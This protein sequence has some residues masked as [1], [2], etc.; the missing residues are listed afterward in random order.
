MTYQESLFAYDFA[1]QRAVGKRVLDVGS[2][3][4]YGAA[5]VAERAKEII[6]LDPHRGIIERARRQYRSSNIQF[7]TGTLEAPPAALAEQRFDLVCC[8]QTIEHV[9]NQGAFLEQLKSFANAGGEVII[10]TPNKGRFPGFNPYHVKE[11]TLHDLTQ[12]MQ[13]HFQ[14]FSVKG[15][16]GDEDVLAYRNSKQRVS[17]TV[18]A[19]DVL[20]AREWLP[21]FLVRSLYVVGSGLVKSLSYRQQPLAVAAVSLKNFWVS[22][23]DLPNALDLLAV[24]EIG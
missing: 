5:Y 6:G 24:G 12:L 1:R 15:I 22:G 4:G 9:S 21:R 2:G 14:R 8:F 3:E 13:A 18:L 10:T 20:K 19:L 7:I 16:F 23:E 17:D 11:L